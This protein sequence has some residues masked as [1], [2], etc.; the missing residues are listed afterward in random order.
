MHKFPYLVAHRAK[1]GL[2]QFFPDL[3]VRD[4]LRAKLAKETSTSNENTSALAK[5]SNLLGV[6]VC[7]DSFK[8]LQ[9]CI[10]GLGPKNM[11]KKFDKHPVKEL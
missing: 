3:V 6:Q 4:S 9:T 10:Q 8:L 1:G 11:A 7:N 5:A 2:L